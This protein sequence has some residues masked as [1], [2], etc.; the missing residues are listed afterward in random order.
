METVDGTGRALTAAEL[1]E[2]LR[3]AIVSGELVPNQRLVE[4]DLAAEYGASR[5][6]IRVA[7]SELSVEGLVERVQNR[8]A[9]VRAV[10]VD[11]AVEIT[12]VRAALEALCARKAAERAT[13][14]DI[15]ELQELAAR[16]QGAVDRG[17][18][19]SYSEGN[20]AM[21]EKIIAMSAQKTAAATIQRLRG[22]AV[23]FQFRL[24]RQPGRPAVSLPQHLAVIDAVCAHDA[25]AAAEAMRVHL[26]S[27]ADAIRASNK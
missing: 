27:V 10:S 22:Q 6:N 1:A 23:R 8:G 26:E 7:L 16:M 9:R 24:A 2:L 3:T 12:E 25:D 14:R 18:R 19:E 21:H 15:E 11:E 17:D 13:E 4:G 5:G 20:Q